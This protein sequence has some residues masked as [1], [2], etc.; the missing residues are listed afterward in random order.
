MHSDAGRLLSCRELPGVI[1]L[2]RCL[3]DLH[4]TTSA[5]F[6]VSESLGGWSTSE[7]K[8]LLTRSSVY[9]FGTLSICRLEPALFRTSCKLLT[10]T[11]VLLL[12]A[13]K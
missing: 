6:G 12:S 8:Y 4:C 2:P 5:D 1:F 7:L 9:I 10:R 13:F 11:R 3:V